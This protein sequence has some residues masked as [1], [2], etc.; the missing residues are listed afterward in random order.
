MAAR[1][2]LRSNRLRGAW[3][4]VCSAVLTL[5]GCSGSRPGVYEY[6]PT[7]APLRYE[8]R[9]SAE[10]VVETPGGPQRVSVEALATLS[11][12]FGAATSRGRRFDATFESASLAALAEGQRTEIETSGLEGA[13]YGGFLGAGG[14]IE[15]T[16]EP[17]LP[18]DL[19]A[20]SDWVSFVTD[21]LFP[22]PPG[23]EETPGGWPHDYVLS[24]ATSIVATA[25]YHG[26]VRFAGDTTWNGRPARL[27]ISEGLA[28]SYGS[29][30]PEG[31]PEEIV[32][33]LEGR[34]VRRYVWDPARG[35]LL[36]ALLDGES[37]G[38]VRAV[39]YD[40]PMTRRSR[41]EA[42]LIVPTED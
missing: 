35:V 3:A 5:A 28:T 10:S 37:A 15:L 41:Q 17:D 33:R 27:L 36:A 1:G 4:A 31:A 21:L 32:F 14:T 40:L 18:P 23:G 16:D 7:G 26:T 13:R 2:S 20:Q 9:A 39:G 25:E 30:T 42:R 29:G 6:Q 38:E 24:I 19:R 11:L 22:P 12:R 8:I 34:K